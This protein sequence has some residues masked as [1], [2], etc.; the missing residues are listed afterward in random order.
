MA[1][2]KFSEFDAG[3][4]NVAGAQLVGLTGGNSVTN[5]RFTASLPLSEII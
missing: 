1:T 5:A 2:I 4:I 3:N